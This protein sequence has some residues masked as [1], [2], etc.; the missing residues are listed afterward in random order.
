MRRG[1][2]GWLEACLWLGVPIFLGSVTPNQ[3][4]H[5]DLEFGS[6]VQIVSPPPDQMSPPVKCNT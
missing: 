4:K 5:A 1:G 6:G 3:V 2:D